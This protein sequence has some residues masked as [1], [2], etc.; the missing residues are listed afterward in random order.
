[1]Y[2]H[3]HSQ[4]FLPPESDSLVRCPPTLPRA[5]GVTSEARP[6]KLLTEMEGRIEVT[7]G[8]G[9]T[10]MGSHRFMG[11]DFQFAM[12]VMV[13]HTVNVLRAIELRSRKWFKW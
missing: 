4:G 12:T 5:Q 10:G 13:V 7:R 11:T 3:K 1:M 2:R 8:F 9:G 6:G